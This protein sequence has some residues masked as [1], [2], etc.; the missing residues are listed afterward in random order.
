MNPEAALAPGAPAIWEANPGNEA[1]THEVG[2]KAKTDALFAQAHRVVRHRV[3]IN[4]VTANSLET[5]GCIGEYDPDQG[6]YTLRAT[7]QSV[8]A[9]RQVMAEHIFKIPQNRMRVVCENMGGGFGMKGGHITSTRFR[10]G[11]PSSS[12]GR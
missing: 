3:V 12:A 10:S 2:D 11:A 9:A 4:R 5:R 8:H 7:V 1:Y 6:R